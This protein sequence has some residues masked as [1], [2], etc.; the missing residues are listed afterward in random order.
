MHCLGQ[1]GRINAA[2]SISGDS[3]FLF[4]DI[5]FELRL[6]GSVQS[7]TGQWLAMAEALQALLACVA[8]VTG[9]TPDSKAFCQR[10][11]WMR[12]KLAVKE[13]PEGIGALRGVPA[14]MGRQRRLGLC[15]GERLFPR[16]IIYYIP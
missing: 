3:L 12:A 11:W 8:G 15:R 1:T 16:I 13:L 10:S 2:E 6:K 14:R 9:R 7:S 5:E 4:T